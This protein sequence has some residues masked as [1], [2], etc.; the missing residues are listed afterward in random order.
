MARIAPSTV[1]VGLCVAVMFAVAGCSAPAAETDSSSAPTIGESSAPAEPTAESAAGCPEELDAVVSAGLEFVRVDPA[2]YVVPGIDEALL[3]TACLY[4]F[5]TGGKTGQ[6]A[7]FPG[8]SPEQITG[9]ILAAGYSL[10]DSSDIAERYTPAS[11]INL[12]VSISSGGAGDP[13]GAIIGP[14]VAVFQDF[15]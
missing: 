9:P 13:V 7:W 4:E 11:G 14:Y 5:T 12:T 1:V 10:L 3:S 6:W 15:S 8:A 2:D